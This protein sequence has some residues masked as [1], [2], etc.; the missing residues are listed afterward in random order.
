M[1]ILFCLGSML[2]LGACSST[3]AMNTSFSSSINGNSYMPAPT[4]ANDPRLYQP[5]FYMD[6]DKSPAEQAYRYLLR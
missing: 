5:Q 6:D 2:L 4:S 3:P 1:K